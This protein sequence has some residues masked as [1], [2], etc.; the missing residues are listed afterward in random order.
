VLQLDHF[1][2][3]DWIGMGRPWTLDAQCRVSRIPD[4]LKRADSESSQ[5]YEYFLE[6]A[7]ARE[8]LAACNGSH[9]SA[10][11]RARVLLYYA[12]HDAW[13]DWALRVDLERPR[14]NAE[15]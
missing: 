14:G 13:P 9:F 11:D 3:D 2:D 7:T 4:D 12:T 10:S 6:I 8:A 5:G 15:F 1:G